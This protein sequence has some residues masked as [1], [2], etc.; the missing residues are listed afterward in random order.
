MPELSDVANDFLR[1]EIETAFAPELR[2]SKAAERG[3][4]LS[5]LDTALSWACWDNLRTLN[6]CSIDEARAVVLRTVAALLHATT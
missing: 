2:A 5:A 4:L 6:H 1:E 3:D